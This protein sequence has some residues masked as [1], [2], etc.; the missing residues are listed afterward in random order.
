MP[1]TNSFSHIA[2]T[3]SLVGVLATGSAALAALLPAG[4]LLRFEPGVGS[5]P[6]TPC[7][8]GSC[9]GMRLAPGYVVWT[10]VAPGTDGGIVIGKWQQSGGQET[11]P[12]PTNSTP[13]EL[14]AAWF[15]FGN[16]GTFFTRPDYLGLENRF[17][18]S[19][20]AK[21]TCVG[22]TELNVFDI[23]WNGNVTPVPGVIAGCG[24]VFPIDEYLIQPLTQQWHLYYSGPLQSAFCGEVYF[25]LIL[26]G[27]VEP[28]GSPRIGTVTIAAPNAAS[29]TW[30]P[31]TGSPPGATVTCQITTPPA[32]GAASVSKDC[33]GGTYVPDP[34][35]TGIDRF[36]YQ[37]RDG[38]VASLIGYVEA[39]VGDCP[40]ALDQS[41]ADHDGRVDACERLPRYAAIP[42]SSLTNNYSQ[43]DIVALNDVG[44]IAGSGYRAGSWRALLLDPMSRQVTELGPGYAWGINNH[45]QVVGCSAPASGNYWYLWSGKDVLMTSTGC[46][47]GINEQSAVVGTNYPTSFIWDPL[48]G[49][50]DIATNF[51][52]RGLNDLGQVVGV[53]WIVSGGLAKTALVWDAVSGLRDLG[54][55]P[56]GTV[57]S[58]AYDINNQGQVVGVSDTSA[59]YAPFIW[60]KTS[61]MRPLPLMHASPFPASSSVYYARAI[62]IN[63]LGLAVGVVGK[64]I[65]WDVDR[66]AMATLASRLDPAAAG[67]T[68]NHVLDINERNQI[69][70]SA[71][72]PAGM[73]ESILLDPVCVPEAVVTVA[74]A[75]LTVDIGAPITL[76][77]TDACGK[78]SLDWGW[79][80]SIGRSTFTTSFSGLPA[81]Q[82]VT[83][84][85]TSPQGQISLRSYPIRV[86]PP[87]VSGYWTGLSSRFGST[88]FIFGVNFRVADGTVPIVQFN[89]LMAPGVQV[90]ASDLLIAL[91]PPGD[92]AGPITVE[93]RAG[94]PA[95]ILGVAKS[96]APYGPPA[97]GLAINGVWPS[98]ARVGSFVFVFGSGFVPNATQVKIN[99]VPA[100][101]V[102][103]VDQS[104]LIFIVPGGARSGPMTVTTAQGSVTS[105]LALEVH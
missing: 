102:Q 91:L 43:I 23:A 103:V 46:A 84:I 15:F 60:D 69:V 64:P 49:T 92:T 16:Y 87:S 3:L 56:G 13:G 90:V 8:S 40:D 6:N 85:I 53:P 39:R 75:T 97:A 70:G 24:G 38:Q 78:L 94:N 27:S 59:G 96:P 35:F 17:D 67:W 80:A 4:T 7:T 66:N 26:R 55:L 76:E 54:D 32:H 18:D 61:G 20:C 14:S 86:G 34:G 21:E 36:V 42:M 100:P 29:T 82:P 83:L 73:S 71:T 72:S 93:T 65:L 45:A 62:A 19:I 57:F 44:Q 9:F 68:L 5:A 12:S 101:Q 22:K 47:V 33:A 95:L 81:V 30:Q 31:Q 58:D 51:F 104:L 37:V 28:P 25:Y 63:D 74:P 41:D 99:D 11:G 48:R 77:A 50:R 52:V 79:G 2:A 105:A 98:V 89:G 1:I 10:D 88:V